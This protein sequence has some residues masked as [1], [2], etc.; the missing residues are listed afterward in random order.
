MSN[1]EADLPFACRGNS[2]SI[3]SGPLGSRSKIS[4]R[5]ACAK[6]A[7][8]RPFTG[9][10]RIAKRPTE[11]ANAQPDDADYQ[12]WQHE[13]DVQSPSN[14]VPRANRRQQAREQRDLLWKERQPEHRFRRYCY[15][16]HEQ[17]RRQSFTQ[18][19]QADFSTR[20][21]E[22]QPFCSDCGSAEYFQPVLPAAPIVFAG[23]TGYVTVNSPEFQCRCGCHIAVHPIS[24]GCFPATPSRPEV[25]YD[26]QLLALTAAAQ[27]AG[28]TAIQAHCS[29]LKQLYKFNGLDS[30]RS[31]LW[32]NLGFA[33]QQWK[34][35]EVPSACLLCKLA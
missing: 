21:A 24:V 8:A 33:A 16:A 23:I 31:A 12:P 10:A 18:N 17:Q 9:P 1:S 15:L 28:P 26:N 4:Y 3:F 34:R 14:Q 30:G 22:L 11:V 25:W 7:H 35:V 27:H 13:Y 5:P 6:R 29:A 2:T 19:M 32:D 20:L